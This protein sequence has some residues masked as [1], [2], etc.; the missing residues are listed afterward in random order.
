MVGYNNT[1]RALEGEIMVET[2]KAILFR[3]VNKSDGSTIKQEWFPKSQLASFGGTYDE[4]EGTFQF[5]LASEW[6]LGQKK[7]LS[8]S[9]DKSLVKLEPSRS[10]PKNPPT[11]Q[12]TMSQSA[13]EIA[14]RKELKDD[15]HPVLGDD[16]PYWNHYNSGE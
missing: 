5:I 11:H 6:V 12:Y 4:I 13:K 2:D 1:Y 3:V 16:D 14:A 15:E 10:V 7:L 8:S 9:V